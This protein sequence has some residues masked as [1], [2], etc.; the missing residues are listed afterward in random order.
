MIETYR[1]Y[2]RDKRELFYDDPFFRV[3]MHAWLALILGDSVRYSSPEISLDHVKT[4][5]NVCLKRDVLAL[6]SRTDLGFGR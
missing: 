4:F 5:L 3:I 1:F 6:S 2:E